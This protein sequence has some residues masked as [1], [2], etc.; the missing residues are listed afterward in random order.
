MSSQVIFV[1]ASRSSIA[2]D[3]LHVAAGAERAA[4]SRDDDRA[5]AGL[6]IQGPERRRELTI[7]LEGQGVESI[8][9]IEGDGGDS[10]RGIVLVEE[11]LRFESH[12]TC[13]Q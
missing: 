1:N 6:G 3:V 11:R 9:P 8:G 4:F 5:H 12:A 13:L 7:D 10:G 2:D